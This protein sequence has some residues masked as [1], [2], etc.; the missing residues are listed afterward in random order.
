MI[1]KHLSFLKKTYLIDLVITNAENAA[2]GKGLTWKIY[3]QLINQGVDYFTMGNHTWH[4]KEVL[5]ILTK[6]NIVRP[7]NLSKCFPYHQGVGSLS[8][9]WQNKTIRLTN[10]LG[11]S[12]NF[13]NKKTNCS[14]TTN[15][16]LCLKEIIH[17]SPPPDLHLVDFHCETT[18]EKN[19][20]MRAFAGQ[21]TAIY[22]THTHV[23]TNDYRIEKNTAYITD[24]GMT[25]PLEGIIGAEPQ[26]ILGYFFGK[27]EYFQIEVAK[28]LRQ[29]SAVL[30]EVNEQ[31]QVTDFFPIILR[32]DF[33]PT[34]AHI[35]QVN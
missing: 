18:S 26:P 19:G 5:T 4:K 1:K 22:G 23:P 25:G 15:P 14:Y 7:A 17:N 31:N 29:L 21:V 34:P 12:V 30:L 10:L 33:Q 27:K 35:I 6:N 24:V 11:N 13:K 32:E 2:H 16:F 28:G 20:L 3:Q 8:F 9:Q